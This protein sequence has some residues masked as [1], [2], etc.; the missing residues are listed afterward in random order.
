MLKWPR[1]PLAQLLKRDANNLDLMRVVCAC[2]VIW[3]HAPLM[4]NYPDHPFGDPVS[5]WLNYEG[6]YSGAIAVRIFFF[7]S[8]LLV[9][10]SLLVKRSAAGFLVARTLRICPALIALLLC[11]V[12]IVGP[13]VSTY[14]TGD[15]FTHVATYRYLWENAFFTLNDSLP[16]VF[17]GDQVNGSLW[18]L[19]TEIECYAAL[20]ILYSF[21]VLAR[22]W[23]CVGIVLVLAAEPLLAHS[24]LF[25]GRDSVFQVRY[26]P[27][28]FGLGAIM[29]IYKKW[30]TLGPEAPLISAVIFFSVKT[31][32]VGQLF[33]F[34]TLFL[35]L[36]YL[37]AL[38]LIRKMRFRADISYGTY[39]WGFLVQQ[40]MATQFPELGFGLHLS[41]SLIISLF[42]GYLSWHLIEKRAIALGH[43]WIE[44]LRRQNAGGSQI[45]KASE[46]S[47]VTS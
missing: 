28:A 37:S 42:L 6:V 38:P 46:I 26:L 15:Y 27:I 14:P 23:L 35:T 7:I 44:T 43:R 47:P 9:T 36:L 29:A 13:L 32:M 20:L 10:N 5:R 22:P 33:F 17:A 2:L 11:T 24:L 30:I 12:F 8:G 4:A 40:V 41:F 31:T 34:L 25:A 3:G 21:G 18:T 39:L 19:S 16:G 1:F 45:P